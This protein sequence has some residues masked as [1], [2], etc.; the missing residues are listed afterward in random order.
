MFHERFE[1]LHNM[2]SGMRMLVHL[3]IRLR[4]RPA[5]LL[6]NL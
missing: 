5:T 3:C 2:S 4:V 1:A 6:L